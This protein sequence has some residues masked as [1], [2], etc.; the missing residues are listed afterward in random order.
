MSRP[1]AVTTL[2]LDVGGVLLTNGWDHI[3][4]KRAAKHFSLPWAE[5]EAR[6][7]LTFE[8]HEEGKLTF[9]EY[10]RLVVFYEKRRFTR[11]QFRRFMLEQ[12]QPYPETIGLF[13]GLKAR[14]GLKVFVVSNESREVN[15][16]RIRKFGLDRLAD[17]FVSS[18]FVH[19]R[20][21]DADIFHLAMDISMVRAENV[22]YIDNTPMFVGIAQGLGIRSIHHEGCESTRVKLGSFG[23][24]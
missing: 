4:R 5:M 10:L 13:T 3:A 14:H 19:L 7:E 16:Y 1:L 12:S 18:C 2:F 11:A 15:A 24:D 6:H 17:G 8:C 22:L 23:L 20:K 21:P 9:E